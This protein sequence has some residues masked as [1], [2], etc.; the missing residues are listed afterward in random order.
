MCDRSKTSRAASQI[1]FIEF[2]VAPIYVQAR[3]W[4]RVGVCVRG[5]GGWGGVGGGRGGARAG[6]LLWKLEMSGIGRQ[7]L[8]GHPPPPTTTA[9]HPFAAHT[10]LPSV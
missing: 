3:H 5:G 4:R 2:V 7:M 8:V 10:T 9:S 6:G 1:N